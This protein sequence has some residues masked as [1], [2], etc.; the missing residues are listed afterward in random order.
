MKKTT[1]ALV[2]DHVLFAESLAKLIFTNARFEHSFSAFSG[3]ELLRKL[4]EKHPDVLILD[5]NLPPFNGLQLIPAI[6]ESSPQTKILMLSMH[7]PADFNLTL[8]QFTADGYLLKTS[9]KDLLLEAIEV[10]T[11]TRTAFFSPDIQW[12]KDTVLNGDHHTLFTRREKQI[13]QLISEGKTSKE[14]AEN[15]HISEHTVKTHRTRI[16]EKMNVSGVAELLNRLNN[17]EV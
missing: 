17:K 10:V 2:D 13:I 9:G 7:H 12:S 15:L 5:I 11:S 14:I 4:T 6:R 16:R 8:D 1:I 3:E